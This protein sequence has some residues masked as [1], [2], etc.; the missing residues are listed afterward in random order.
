VSSFATA[1]LIIPIITFMSGKF[2]KRNA[3]IISIL[4]STVGYIFKWW[5]FQ[6]AI[7]THWLMFV[8]LP[9]ISFGIGGLFTLMMSMTADAC[10]YD[11]L[12]NGMP[13]KEATFGAIYWWM[14]KLGTSL[15]VLAGGFILSEVG[16]DP[17]LPLQTMDTLTKLRLADIIIPVITG[18]LAILIMWN[19]NIT[20][21]RSL[22]IRKIL[23][24]RRGEL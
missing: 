10:D 14:V 6:Y 7:E 11:E 18:L 19:Y 3:F 12:K 13:R 20:E 1:F 4:I 24:E 8:P 16:F 2:G 9:L 22:E 15:A 23:V 5:A 17:A 21:K